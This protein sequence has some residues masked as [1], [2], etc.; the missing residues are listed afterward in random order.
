MVGLDFLLTAVCFSFL[1]YGLC[2]MTLS[3]NNASKKQNVNPENQL[4][5]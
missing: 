4:Q 3:V 5:R 2:Y 1:G